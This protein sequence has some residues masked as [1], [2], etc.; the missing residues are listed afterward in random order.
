MST[1][2]RPN[3]TAQ[4]RRPAP[5]RPPQRF[6]RWLAVLCLLAVAFVSGFIWW[7]IR[8]DSP[9][10]SE[11]QASPPGRH[12]TDESSTSTGDAAPEAPTT[13]QQGGFTFESVASP[14]ATGDCA[15][16]SYGKVKN[17]FSGHPCERVVR[18]LYTTTR[19]DARAIVSVI[20][21]TMPSDSDATE[22]KRITDTSGTGNV[23]DMLRD[24]TA[25][26]PGAPKVSGGTYASDASGEHVTI[27]ETALYDGR[28]D[29]ALL[30][31]IAREAL[32]VAT[33]LR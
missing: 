15:T 18:G 8:H 31:E 9:G 29:S 3:E 24:G 20:V 23:S 10:D 16:V 28:Q 14:S 2:V 4:L 22:L 26:V 33:R 13:V 19:D 11:Q 7:L 17:W 30:D 21:V 1:P 32:L 12:Q 6:N 5:A 25:E 27:I